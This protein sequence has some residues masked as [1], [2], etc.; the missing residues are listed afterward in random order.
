MYLVGKVE[1]VHPNGRIVFQG[2]VGAGWMADGPRLHAVHLGVAV[3]MQAG[4]HSSAAA[5]H[6]HQAA[7]HG[8]RSA[9]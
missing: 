7:P 5:A 1:G 9:A 8:W 6:S 4:G 3:G 2:Q